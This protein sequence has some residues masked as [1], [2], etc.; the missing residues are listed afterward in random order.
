VLYHYLPFKVC[1]Y[2]SVA[3]IKKLQNAVKGLCVNIN[4][5]EEYEY[6]LC[7]EK[8]SVFPK[9]GGYFLAVPESK[10]HRIKLPQTVYIT[11]CGIVFYILALRISTTLSCVRILYPYSMINMLSAMPSSTSEN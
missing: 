7:V 4:Q 10:Y 1:G 9:A 11:A 8:V 5:K 6:A 2:T 3:K